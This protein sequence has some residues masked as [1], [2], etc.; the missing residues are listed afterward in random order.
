M[1]DWAAVHTTAIL[2]Q[3]LGANRLDFAE[4]AT[5]ASA[6]CDK[7]DALVIVLS[8]RYQ[9]ACTLLGC[10]NLAVIITHCLIIGKG[11]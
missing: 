11:E 8:A 3:N 10:N 1:R 5:E 7:Q 2:P 4:P 6:S 9:K